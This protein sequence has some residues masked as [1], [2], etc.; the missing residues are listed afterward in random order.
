MTPRFLLDTDWVIDHLNGVTAITQRLE[1]L[2]PH[3]LTLSM[4]SL[5]E[6]YEGVHYSRDPER[7]R[8]VLLQFIAGVTVLPVDDE[9]CD[10]FGRERGNLRR[11]GRTVG[12][13]DLLIGATALRHDL[14]L[15]TNNRRHFEMIGGVRLVDVA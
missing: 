10:I 1:D 12:D 11:Q 2:R 6:L 15:R 14:T 5:A 3:A 8:R 9:V 7:S 4:I 13:F